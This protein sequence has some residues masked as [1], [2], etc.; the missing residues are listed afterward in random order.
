[1]ELQNHLNWIENEIDNFYFCGSRGLII[2][3]NF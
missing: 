3:K 2:F 1:M